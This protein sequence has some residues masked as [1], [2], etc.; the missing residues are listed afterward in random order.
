MIQSMTWISLVAA[1]N[2]EYESKIDCVDMVYI[3]L[4]S[5]ETARLVRHHTLCL[6]LLRLHQRSIR[7][8][9]VCKVGV[10]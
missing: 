9:Q 2:L 7:A 3:L 10:K 8:F 6:E 5:F 1:I 4:A